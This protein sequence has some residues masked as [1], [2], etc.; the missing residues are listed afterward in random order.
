MPIRK[1][2]PLFIVFLFVISSIASA[3][4]RSK[5]NAIRGKRAWI[6]FEG[7]SLAT[8]AGET[9]KAERFFQIGYSEGKR[10]LEELKAGKIKKEDLDSEVPTIMLLL[11]QG[12]SDDFILG[13]IFENAQ[14]HVLKDIY[15]KAETEESRRILARDALFRG[16]YDLVLEK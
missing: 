9:K 7:S 4:E 14:D 13:R 1:T 16:N 15:K 6:A 5:K 2:L 12:P 3:E 8:T 10:F 11:V